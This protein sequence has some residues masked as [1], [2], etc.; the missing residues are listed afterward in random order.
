MALEKYV[1][2]IGGTGARVLRSFLHLCASGVICS[3]SPVHAMVVD[4]DA[5]N[6]DI[7]EALTLY[8]QYQTN[9]DN[10]H[11]KSVQDVLNALSDHRR[12][13]KRWEAFRPFYTKVQLSEEGGSNVLSKIRGTNHIINLETM[14]KPAGDN[15]R[16]LRWFY[17][18]QECEQALDDGF[19]AHPNI[20]SIFFL[21][22]GDLFK[23]FTER[24]CADMREGKDVSV[25]I[26]GS[27]FG[28]TG[29]AG[30]PSVLRIIEEA[31]R[32]ADFPPD[33]QQLLHMNAVLVTPYFRVRP[34]QGS[35]IHIDS[36]TFFGNTKS[37]LEFYSMRYRDRFERLYLAGQND[38]E[39][40]S[41]SYED[42]GI[43][44]RN[45]PHIVEL[46][47]ALAVKDSWNLSDKA[48]GLDIREYIL[49]RNGNEALFGWDT[50]DE[51]LFYLAH[52]LRT[53]FLIKS[54][55]VPAVAD[56]NTGSAWFTT[57]G[58]LNEQ[59]TLDLMTQYTD[60]FLSW[61]YEIQHRY[62]DT[63]ISRKVLDER[64]TLCGLPLDGLLSADA[65][66][67]EDALDNFQNLIDKGHDNTQAQTVSY[68]N[69][70]PERI[71]NDLGLFGFFERDAKCLAALKTTGLF[72]QL[73]HDA[74]KRV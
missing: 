4:V 22:M 69:N 56:G 7:T 41:S 72:I 6:G 1:F 15:F 24:I 33:K 8:R 36:E 74:N 42:G 60:S 13:S 11:S 26:V 20:G 53:Q 16:A 43:R 61:M 3:D 63:N 14:T 28:G 52:M 45:K 67:R 9:Y 66:D 59:P 47:A 34:P 40:V 29:A 37:A 44:Q 48:N 32:T 70:R 55:I 65:R 49:Q 68:R 21:S 18:K 35:N 64:I 25:V 12:G 62:A 46:I 17:T 39:Y 73:F 51:E 2:F 23:T 57:F 19:F 5:Q 58:M 71:M 38:L 54:C 31:C 27:M 10:I 50:L 30:I